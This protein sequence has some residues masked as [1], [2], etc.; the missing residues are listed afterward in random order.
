MKE[1]V[2]F[3]LLV[4]SVVV[5]VIPFSNL[6]FGENETDWIKNNAKWLAEGKITEEENKAALQYLIKK[7]ILSIFTNTDTKV[8]PKAL[9]L[10]ESRAQSYVVRFSNGE[11]TSPLEISTF[12]KYSTDKSLGIN[13]IFALESNPSRDKLEFYN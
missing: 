10:D 6:V 1:G 7:G 11:F 13:P 5:F 4:A 9:S 2:I 3:S 12:S 8:E